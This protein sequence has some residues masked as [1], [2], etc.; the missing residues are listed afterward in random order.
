MS[1]FTSE[2]LNEGNSFKTKYICVC[3]CVYCLIILSLSLSI[4]KKGQYVSLYLRGNHM[5]NRDKCLNLVASTYKY[6][7]LMFC[8]FSI[9]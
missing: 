9:E 8:K 4:A 5:V 1:L 7:P 6:M 2:R 3:V